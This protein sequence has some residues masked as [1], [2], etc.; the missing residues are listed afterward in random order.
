MNRLAELDLDSQTL[1]DSI[2]AMSGDLETKA[3]NVAMY[4]KNRTAIIDAMKEAEAQMSARRQ[5]AE[6]KNADLIAYLKGTMERCG[7]LKIEG[8]MFALAIRTNP[9]A[10]VVDSIDLVPAEFWRTP[11]PPP[12]VIDK[13]AIKAAIT[14]GAE[15][16]GAHIEKSTRIDIK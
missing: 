14:G 12:P 7:V 16:P 1:A 13:A 6:K 5:V 11:T 2:E 8:P 9:G 15:V 3:L 4:V 10:V